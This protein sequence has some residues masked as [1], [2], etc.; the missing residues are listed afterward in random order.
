MSSMPSDSFQ[1]I[2][3]RNTFLIKTEFMQ[4]RAQQKSSN[5]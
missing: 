2:R 5:H 3:R 4:A 1:E